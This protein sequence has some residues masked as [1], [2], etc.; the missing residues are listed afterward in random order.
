MPFAE[1]SEKLQNVVLERI[2]ERKKYH[3]DLEGNMVPFAFC[4]VGT[5]APIRESKPTKY[6]AQSAI[7]PPK[8][9]IWDP[10]DEKKRFEKSLRW[11]RSNDTY[12]D[13]D[14]GKTVV[15]EKIENITFEG[16]WCYAQEDELD[17]IA[18]LMFAHNNVSKPAKLQK[19]GAI[20][21]LDLQWEERKEH[22][23]A[24]HD[25]NETSEARTL[26]LALAEAFKTSF[27]RKKQILTILAQDKK[28][29]HLDPTGK[30]TDAIENDFFFYVKN[31]PLEFLNIHVDEKTK[32]QVKLNDLKYRGLLKHDEAKGSWRLND[33]P[34]HK[35]QKATVTDPDAELLQAIMDEHKKAESATK[36][37]EGST[38]TMMYWVDYH[39]REKPHPYLPR[40]EEEAAEEELTL[41]E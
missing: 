1:L 38:R 17:K 3:R 9:K 14:K 8:V 20:N 25:R 23:M 21:S 6:R 16:G 4:L 7:L 33:K 24:R 37:S 12:Y 13:H 19:I 36:D 35:Y 26:Q 22:M 30:Q 41:A 15:D 32:L 5:G 11:V 40:D 29:G 18:I 39:L 31:F 10:Y 34:F 2:A 28:R 27:S